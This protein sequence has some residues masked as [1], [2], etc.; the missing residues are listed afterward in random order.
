MR[1]LTLCCMQISALQ[2]VVQRECEEREELLQTLAELKAQRT[3]IT[4]KRLK[5][6]QTK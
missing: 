1:V 3:Q 6:H 5:H 2:A 4:H